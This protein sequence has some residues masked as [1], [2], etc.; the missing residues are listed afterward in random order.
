MRIGTWN[1]QRGGASDRVATRQMEALAA[2]EFDVMVLT[3]PPAALVAK[4]LRPLVAS[5]TEREGTRGLEAWVAIVGDG[6]VEAEPAVP[7]EGL[8][9]VGRL[10]R[11]TPPTT[12]VGAVLPWLNA[13]AQAPE[14]RHGR[15]TSFQMFKR[16]LE[17][18]ADVVRD[19]RLRYPDDLVVWAG[20][21]NQTLTGRQ[22]GGGSAARRGALRDCLGALGLAAWNAEA[23]HACLPLHAIDLICGPTDRSPSLLNV[24][25]PKVGVGP[26]SDHAGYLVAL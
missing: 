1:L 18:Q 3:E 4:E 20:D 7:F 24:L 10:P 25:W 13:P 11:A 2:L 22:Q 6:L 14:L 19:V 21:F 15:E 8:A 26:L 16:L 9:T 12:V 23:P 5:P 17:S